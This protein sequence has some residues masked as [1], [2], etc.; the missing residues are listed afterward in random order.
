MAFEQTKFELL[1]KLFH[2]GVPIISDAN[3]LLEIFFCL[4][5]ISERLAFVTHDDAP[6]RKKAQKNCLFWMSEHW[7]HGIIPASKN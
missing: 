3:T 6:K 7:L 2:L 4:F 1:K 5:K